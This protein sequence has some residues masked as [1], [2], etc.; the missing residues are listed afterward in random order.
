M[1]PDQSHKLAKFPLGLGYFSIISASAIC[2][3]TK[4]RESVSL[5]RQEVHKMLRAPGLWLRNILELK[6]SIREEV[7]SKRKFTEEQ[8][9]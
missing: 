1:Q 4:E 6:F 7:R 5:L 3:L 2:L 8:R 9:D